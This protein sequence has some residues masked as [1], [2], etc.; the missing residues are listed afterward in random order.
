MSRVTICIPVRN[1]PAY[2]VDAVDSVLAQ[3]FRDWELVIVDD[4]SDDG[5]TGI[6]ARQLAA[7]DLRIFTLERDTRG[8]PGPARNDGFWGSG[9]EFLLPLDS[10]DMLEPTYLEETLAAIGDADV[11]F[12]D[13]RQFGQM[14]DVVKMGPWDDTLYERNTVPCCSLIRQSAF[15]DVGGY[16]DSIPW[17]EDYDLWRMLYASGCTAVHVPRPLWQ[18]RRHAEQWTAAQ[19]GRADSERRLRAKWAAGPDQYVRGDA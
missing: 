13:Y 3:T 2:L 1:R 14:D 12:T 7:G 4:A 19:P 17:I 10:D 8:G 5:L 16:D 18:Y 6:M 15:E 11:C 9:S